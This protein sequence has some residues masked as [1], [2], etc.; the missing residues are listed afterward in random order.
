MKNRQQKNHQGSKKPS[1]LQ[2]GKLISSDGFQKQYSLLWETESRY[3][4]PG[5]AVRVNCSSILADASLLIIA[6][7]TLTGL[8]ERSF[9]VLMMVISTATLF[10]P[11]LVMLPKVIFLNKTAFLMPCSAGLFVGGTSVYFRNTKSSSLNVIK[12]LRILSVLWCESGAWSR[13][14]L[15]RLRISLQAERYSVSERAGYAL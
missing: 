8:S 14:F 12:R 15:N 11:R 6:F 5:I 3:G 13:S 7:K 4:A 2:N 10:L 1:G 9:A